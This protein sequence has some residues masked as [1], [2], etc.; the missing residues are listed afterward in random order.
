MAEVKKLQC[1]L[2]M[3]G[4]DKNRKEI[5]IVSMFTYKKKL[6]LFGI[7]LLKTIT[8]LILVNFTYI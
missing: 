6:F 2:F 3:F 7:V 8:I 5:K 1:F 4:M